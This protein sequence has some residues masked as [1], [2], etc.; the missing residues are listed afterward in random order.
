MAL[1]DHLRAD[2]DVELASGEFRQERGDCAAP[3]DRVAV[4]ARDARA[5][6]SRS[7]L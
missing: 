6:E 4:Y 2:E 3:A 5:G 1:G 7:D